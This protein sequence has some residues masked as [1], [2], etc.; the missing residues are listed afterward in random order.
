MRHVNEEDL[1]GI[2]QL[3]ETLNL[4]AEEFDAL[5]CR[6]RGVYYL[7]SRAFLHFHEHKS[8]I[9]ADVRLDGVEFDRFKVTTRT[10][11]KELVSRIKGILNR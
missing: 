1:A 2:E 4:L 10:D 9:Y 5:R 6:K 7:K 8:E 3:L 11:Q